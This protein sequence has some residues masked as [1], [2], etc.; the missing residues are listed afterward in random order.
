M[1]VYRVAE[2][3]DICETAK[4]YNVMNARTNIGL[5]IRFGK[6]ERVFRAQFVSNKP[7]TDSVRQYNEMMQLPLMSY[8]WYTSF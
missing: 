6:E 7:I 4:V 1:D 3:R 8:I 2:I 5:K